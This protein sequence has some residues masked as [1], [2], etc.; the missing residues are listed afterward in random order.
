MSIWESRIDLTIMFVY[1]HNYFIIIWWVIVINGELMVIYNISMRENLIKDSL[2]SI[3][4]CFNLIRFHIIFLF[5]IQKIIDWMIIK[6]S[7]LNNL[8]FYFLKKNYHANHQTIKIH[9]NNKKWLKKNNYDIYLVIILIFF[10][11]YVNFY[12]S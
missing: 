8:I 11:F 2:R 7:F 4:I 9:Q 5:N 10:F 12:G 6:V 3:L 1:N